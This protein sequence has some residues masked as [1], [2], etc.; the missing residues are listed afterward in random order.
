LS[1]VKLT[2]RMPKGRDLTNV[3]WLETLLTATTTVAEDNA[4]AKRWQDILLTRSSSLPFPLVFETNED[5]V[6]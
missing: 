5:M 4:Q 6:W 1:R 2:S 3:K